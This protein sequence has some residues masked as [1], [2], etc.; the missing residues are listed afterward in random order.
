MKE[1]KQKYWEKFY[2]QLVPRRDRV[3]IV[4]EI[5]SPRKLL[6]LYQNN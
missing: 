5:K 3:R 1:M 4:F 6:N 2:F